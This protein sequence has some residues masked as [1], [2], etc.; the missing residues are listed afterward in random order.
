[1]VCGRLAVELRPAV[2]VD[3][4]VSTASLNGKGVCI[5]VSTASIN[6]KTVCIY[7]SNAF[8]NGVNVGI[9]GGIPAEALCWEEACGLIRR[10]RGR[11]AREQELWAS[12]RP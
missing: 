8:I 5:D 7:V 10:R 4:N 9:N 2:V 1:M 11:Q 3:I 12:W 6:G